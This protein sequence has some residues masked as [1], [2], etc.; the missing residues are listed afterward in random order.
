MNFGIILNASSFAKMHETI[1]PTF[2]KNCGM[3]TL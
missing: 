1:Y 2:R 3:G